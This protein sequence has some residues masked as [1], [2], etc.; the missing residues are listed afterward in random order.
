MKRCS[1]LFG[2]AAFAVAVSACGDDGGSNNS[3]AMVQ[4][5]ADSSMPTADAG[6]VD[7]GPPPDAMRTELDER[8]VNYGEALRTASL[9]LTGAQPA[10]DDILAIRDAADDAARKVLYESMVD[11][12]L[13]TSGFTRQ[14]IALWRNILRMRL[15]LVGGATVS[16]DTAP[17]FAARLMVSGADFSTLF[18]ATS[19]TCPTYNEK[20]D[21]F[22]DAECNNGVTPSGILT[23]PGIYEVYRGNLALRSVR[24]FHETFLCR[25]ALEP[26][27]EPTATSSTVGAC[28]QAQ[29]PGY[30]S[31]WDEDSITGRCN[32]TRTGE[33]MWAVE[34]HE[35]TGNGACGNCHGTFNHR[36]PLFARFDDSG[37]Y[38]PSQFE[39]FMAID[40]EPR[41]LATDFLPAGES[42]AYKSGS[43]ATT[44]GELGTLMANDPEVH[45]CLVK[46]MWN[47]AMSHGDIVTDGAAVPDSVVADLVIDFQND[48][49]NLKNVLRAVFK[50]DDFVRF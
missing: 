11:G 4:P 24:Y 13:E 50:H 30:D 44:I 49:F 46:R 37:Q 40:G 12:M 28:G 21:T 3:D 38:S 39:V 19:S 15:N 1:L 26:R 9:K 27:A 16:H 45:S 23:N 7:A 36:A 20:A 32:S 8:V 42:P 2:L 48:G 35:P 29:S 5:G 14:M 43:P 10:L 31:P 22:T 17:T 18:T 33:S 34:F 47:F 25:S 41:A 6:V